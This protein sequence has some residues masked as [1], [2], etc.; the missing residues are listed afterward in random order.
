MVATPQA[1]RGSSRLPGPG[2][3][4]SDGQK[5]VQA[6]VAGG[7]PESCGETHARIG[8]LSTNLWGRLALPALADS[9]LSLAV[10]D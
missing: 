4:G 9:Q 1:R 7:I 3:L 10:W 5:P 8:E 6:L 2:S